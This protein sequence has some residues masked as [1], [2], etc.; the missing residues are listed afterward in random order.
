MDIGNAIRF[1]GIMIHVSSLATKAEV[2]Q[3]LQ[4]DS[5]FIGLEP[6]R[7]RYEAEFGNDLTWRY[8]IPD[9]TITGAIFLP[10]QEGF[11]WMPYA[12]L[13][14]EFMGVI[15]Y[16][17]IELL[18]FEGALVLF[19]EYM[20]YSYQLLSALSDVCFTLRRNLFIKDVN[21]SGN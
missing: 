1:M 2:L 13:E 11:L 3:T 17:E 14:P 12:D 6:I 15:T 20:S 10:V 5:S 7:S 19:E 21:E 9:G 8:P 4:T 16:D 18:D